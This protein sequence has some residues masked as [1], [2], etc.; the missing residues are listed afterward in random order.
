M[1]QVRWAERM[2]NSDKVITDRW[3][4]SNLSVTSND[5]HGLLTA[6]VGLKMKQK[7]YLQH[8]FWNA[9]HK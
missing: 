2:E 1:V 4:V 3:L 8:E 5:L 7:A 6:W 9:C